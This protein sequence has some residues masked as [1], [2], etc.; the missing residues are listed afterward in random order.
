MKQV[1]EIRVLTK[2]PEACPDKY[3]NRPIQY[4]APQAVPRG[5]YKLA[6]RDRFHVCQLTQCKNFTWFAL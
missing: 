1:A 4:M 6:I 5:K 2:R 3:M